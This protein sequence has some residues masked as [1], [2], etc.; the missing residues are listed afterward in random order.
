MSDGDIA[1]YVTGSARCEGAADLGFGRRWELRLGGRERLG[2]T[3]FH[4]G[5]MQH[6]Q[7]SALRLILAGDLPAMLLHHS[8]D[9]AQ[10]QAGALADGLR[11]IE[12]IEHAM[13]L[14]YARPVI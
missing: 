9:R 7:G 5:Q 10:S 14:F 1:V 8:I 13:R 4:D 11:G 6:E 2:I 3:L 12:R